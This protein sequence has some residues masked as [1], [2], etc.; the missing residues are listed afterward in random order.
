MWQERTQLRT[1]LMIPGQNNWDWNLDSVLAR[2][3]CPAKIES[4]AVY[5]TPCLNLVGTT[6]CLTDLNAVAKNQKRITSCKWNCHLPFLVFENPHFCHLESISFKV[7]SFRCSL[8]KETEFSPEWNVH[9]EFS[10][11]FSPCSYIE[12]LPPVSNS[13]VFVGIISEFSINGICS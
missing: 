1:L 13:C 4:C 12:N 11:L 7:S 2:P 5:R 3:L 6:N 8:E 10:P 9:I